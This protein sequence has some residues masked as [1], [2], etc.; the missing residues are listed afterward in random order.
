MSARSTPRVQPTGPPLIAMSPPHYENLSDTTHCRC[1]RPLIIRRL[2]QSAGRN[3]QWAEV[4][5]VVADADCGD[6]DCLPY[7]LYW[8]GVLVEPEPPAGALP[9]PPVS[10]A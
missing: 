9:E 4:L 1:G 5:Y 3:A 6:P 10:W 2:A 7:V 8:K